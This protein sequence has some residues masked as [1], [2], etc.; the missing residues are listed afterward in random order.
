MTRQKSKKIGF[1]TFDDMQALDLFG[2]LEVFEAAN[3]QLE[4]ASCYQLIVLSRDGQSVTTSSG[5]TVGAHYAL[6]NCPPLHSLI[7][8]GGQGARRKN[9][10]GQTLEWIRQQAKDLE[11]ICSVCTGLFVL[12]RTGLVDGCSTTT[13][14]QH[15][16]EACNRFPE[17][18]IEPDALFIRQG[19]FATS[20]GVT[21]GID[22]ALSLV[23]ED[24]GPSLAAKVA[25]HLVVFVRRPGDQRQF[26]SPL[27][28]QMRT[29]DAFADLIAWISEHLAEPLSASILAEQV[30]LSERQ[31]RRR[32][33]AL[34]GQTPIK[35]VEQLRIETACERLLEDS[36]SIEQI[37]QS[38]GY[39]SALSFRRAFV[40]LRGVSPSEFRARFSGGQR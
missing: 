19:K 23:E 10:S 30:N 18:Q 4:S 35:Y 20:A 3:G 26:S 25:Q 37:A 21:A 24:F 17:L 32:F 36:T 33:Q 2:P 27:R 22:L 16:D 9:F 40:R 15:V 31:F 11:R 34:T 39:D 1:L 13:H 38:V 12:A 5:V 6:K 29:S 28:E 8:A 7:I 14:W